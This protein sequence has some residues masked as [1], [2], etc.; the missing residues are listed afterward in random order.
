MLKSTNQEQR[1]WLPNPPST[2]NLF[3]DAPGR[4]GRPRSEDYNRWHRQAMQELYLQK[5][6]R[7]DGKVKLAFFFGL[8]S[9]VADC[10]NFIKAPEDLLVEAGIIAGDSAK[11][12]QGL[13]SCWVPNYVG[14][15][16]HVTP[17]LDSELLWLGFDAGVL[18]QVGS[19]NPS[20]MGIHPR[21][22]GRLYSGSGRPR[23]NDPNKVGP[24][25]RA[26]KAILEH[27]GAKAQELLEIAHVTYSTLRNARKELEKQTDLS[28][29]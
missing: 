17:Y 21:A 22:L 26:M 10:S 15:V 20:K 8:R 13:S 2:N 27:P 16:V 24:R 1:F 9:P 19:A 5:P 3:I 11:F 6:R 23:T 18:G 12:V 4:S 14:M 29:T 28:R 25:Q 7:L